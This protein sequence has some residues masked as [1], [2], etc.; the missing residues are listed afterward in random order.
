M[1]KLNFHDFYDYIW[2]DEILEIIVSTKYIDENEDFIRQLTLD[3]FRFYELSDSP[4]S[5]F[6]KSIEIM[7]TNL[8]AFHPKT[9]NIKE[10]KDNYPN[11][12]GDSY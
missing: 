1:N 9:K 10:I 5:Y 4:P 7:F 2:E 8:F 6:K 3:M 11:I 12:I